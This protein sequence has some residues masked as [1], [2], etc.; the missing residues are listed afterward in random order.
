MKTKNYG[1][2]YPVSLITEDICNNFHYWDQQNMSFN[3]ISLYLVKKYVRGSRWMKYRS[4][5][6]FR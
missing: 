6:P 4:Y 3:P 2:L 5:A 1:L